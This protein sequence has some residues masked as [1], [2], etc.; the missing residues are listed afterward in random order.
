MS[1]AWRA[2][3][4]LG[5]RRTLVMPA[6]GLQTPCPECGRGTSAHINSLASRRFR[7]SHAGDNSFVGDL[8]RGRPA[9]A[10]PASSFFGCR[11]Q[12]AMQTVP[13]HQTI[14]CR[15]IDRGGACGARHVAPR[16]THELGEIAELKLRDEAVPRG[17][18]RLFGRHVPWRTPRSFGGELLAERRNVLG[19]DLDA[20]LEQDDHVLDDV[21]EL[22]HVALPGPRPPLRGCG[23]CWR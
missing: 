14:E 2:R 5:E 18:V 12:F 7:L 15:A 1:R 21:L 20:G 17:V 13:L 3:A 19:A 6:H 22:A 23:W 9:T 4:G 16:P 11:Q 8:L 10:S